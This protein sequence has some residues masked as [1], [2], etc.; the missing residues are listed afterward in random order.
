[1]LLL[2]QGVLVPFISRAFA[3]TVRGPFH[4]AVKQPHIV[5]VGGSYGGL[6]ALRDLIKLSAG[7]NLEAGK[8]GPR[9]PPPGAANGAGGRPA[10]P[11]DMVGPP[12]VDRALNTKPRYTLIDER[13]GFCKV[14]QSPLSYHIT[15]CGRPYN[16]IA[17]GSDC[18]QLRS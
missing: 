12:R 13:D 7:Q 11:P 4:M 10:G 1:M 3:T 18:A 16:G 2:R 14:F 5:I 15:N 9:G 17:T 6:A 8:G